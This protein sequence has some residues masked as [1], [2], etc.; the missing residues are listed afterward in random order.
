MSMATTESSPAAMTASAGSRGRIIMVEDDQEI[1]ESIAEY[2]SV[3]GFDVTAVG[4]GI[5]FYQALAEQS[6]Q[7]A[8]ID[9]GLPDINGDQGD[10]YK[11]ISFHREYYN[12][13]PVPLILGAL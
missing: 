13:T 6:F 3:V 4:T 2:L 10:R 9:I 7:L 11:I 1:R 5:K 12:F 8:V